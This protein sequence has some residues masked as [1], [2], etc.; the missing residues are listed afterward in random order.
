MLAGT[1]TGIAL[2]MM[3]LVLVGAWSLAYLFRFKGFG[4]KENT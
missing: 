2:G 3:A 4:R 1:P